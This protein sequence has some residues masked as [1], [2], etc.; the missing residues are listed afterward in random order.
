LTAVPALGLFVLLAETDL[1]LAVGT[2]FATLQASASLAAVERA[3]DELRA[4]VGA[5]MKLLA[6]AQ[7]VVTA[8]AVV[9]GPEL[10]QALALPWLSLFV[11]R[12]G[13]MAAYFQVLF[14]ATLVHLL[15]LDL[16]REAALL[17]LLLAGLNVALTLA[18]FG[19][20]LPAYGFGYAGACALALGAACWTLD[21]AL[22]DLER[23]VFTRQ[24]L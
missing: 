11:F 21:A 14:M 23:T 3:R 9:F 12:V 20:G 1:A 4:T 13:A 8:A 7:G 6:L 19:G 24:P 22:G 18:S 10:V 16:A 5:N 15:Y 2:Y 17:A